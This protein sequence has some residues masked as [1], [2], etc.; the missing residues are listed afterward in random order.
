MFVLCFT[1]DQLKNF[2]TIAYKIISA[3]NKITPEE[4][5]AFEV[6]VNSYGFSNEEVIKNEKSLD[7]LLKVFNDNPSKTFCLLNLYILAHVD[8]DFSKE[9]KEMIDNIAKKIGIKKENQ[10]KILKISQNMM[11]IFDEIDQVITTL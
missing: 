1:P 7:E 8:K 5:K 9:E 3:D 11:K 10:E 6:L 4:K 2:V